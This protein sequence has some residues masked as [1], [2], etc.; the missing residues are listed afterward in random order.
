MSYKTLCY[1]LARMIF[2]N[3]D[4]M[5]KNNESKT[6]HS[7]WGV[8]RM[9]KSTDKGRFYSLSESRSHHNGGN[10][11]IWTIRKILGL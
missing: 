5:S 1:S 7:P 6:C 11:R 4:K 9:Y 2:A 8:F 3:C 10:L